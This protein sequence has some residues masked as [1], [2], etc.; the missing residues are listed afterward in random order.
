MH[1]SGG[2]D[3]DIVK[4]LLTTANEYSASDIHIDPTASCVRIRLRIDGLL[5]DIEPLA[6]YTHAEAINRIKNLAGL[7]TDEHRL[8]QLLRLPPLF[9]PVSSPSWRR[10]ASSSEKAASWL[11]TNACGGERMGRTWK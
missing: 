7:R 1:A 10:C 3:N 2:A 11:T 8:P 9:L 4:E 5:R 6:T